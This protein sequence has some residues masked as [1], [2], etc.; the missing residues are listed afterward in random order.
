MKQHNWRNPIL[1]VKH[2]PLIEEAPIQK[3]EE[4]KKKERERD[5]KERETKKKERKKRRKKERKKERRKK[6]RRKK[7]KERKR[8]CITIYLLC[9]MSCL[10]FGFGANTVNAFWL[11]Q[12]M[13]KCQSSKSLFEWTEHAL[14]D[15]Y[16][17]YTV[18]CWCLDKTWSTMFPLTLSYLWIS[19]SAMRI[20]FWHGCSFSAYFTGFDL[21]EVSAGFACIAL[22]LLSVAL[23]L[24][25]VVTGASWAAWSPVLRL[26]TSLVL[27]A[28]VVSVVLAF[29][30]TRL[31]FV[32][33]GFG[34]ISLGSGIFKIEVI[35]ALTDDAFPYSIDETYLTG[36][37]QWYKTEFSFK[38]SVS[39]IRESIKTLR[40][41]FSGQP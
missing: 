29:W 1:L 30:F 38:Q 24:Y 22:L 8:C 28:G 34:F 20:C 16:G 15:F 37:N 35:R 7:K 31:G 26:P 13:G 10:F 14:M 27:T 18:Y 11:S 19:E 25:S 4:E 33:T 5:K 17:N 21:V 41:K 23:G 36:F 12:K 6:E 32:A 40:V 3:K 9:W 39:H 2:F